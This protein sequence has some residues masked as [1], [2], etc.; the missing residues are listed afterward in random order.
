MLMKSEKRERKMKRIVIFFAIIG[1]SAGMALGQTDIAVAKTNLWIGG[2]NTYIAAYTNENDYSFDI[3]GRVTSPFLSK[4]G[5]TIIYI[6]DDT[7]GIRFRGTG[8]YFELETNNAVFKPGVEVT[9]WSGVIEQENG[10]RSVRSKIYDGD[11]LNEFN[12]IFISDT[13]PVPVVPQLITLEEYFADG[14][15]VEGA[16]IKIT[17]LTCGAVTWPYGENGTFTA[18]S[19]ASSITVYLDMDTEVPG[20]LPPTNAFDL[21]GIALQYDISAIPSNGYEIMPRYYSDF[22]QTVG[23]EPPEILVTP[24]SAT[25]KV[26][27]PITVDVI[28]Q[29]R[30]AADVLTIANPEAISGSSFVSTGARTKQLSWT[31]QLSDAGTIHTAVFTVADATVTVTGQTVITVADAYP[32]GYAWINEVHYNNVGDDVNEGVELA[33]SAGEDLG[34]YDVF[35]YRGAGTLVSSNACGGNIDDEGNGYGA[36]WFGYPKDA[37]PNTE[38]HGVALVHDVDGVMDFIS[39]GGSITATEGPASG[40]TSYDIGVVENP[41]PEL[42]YSLQLSGD[43]TNY[44]SF[45]WTGPVPASRGFLNFAQNVGGTADAAVIMFDLALLPAEPSTNAFDIVCSIFPNGSADSLSATAYYTLNGGT[46]NSVPMSLGEDY[47]YTTSSQIP[48]QPDGTVVSYWVGVTFG[49]PGTNSPSFTETNTYNI[50]ALAGYETFANFDPVN[51]GAYTDGDFLGQDGSTWTYTQCRGDMLITD[52]TPCLGNNRTPVAA[53]QSGTI[54]GGCGTLSFDLMKAFSADYNLEVYVNDNLVATLTGG[55]QSVVDSSGDIVVNAQ[56]DFVLKF[57]QA[58]SAAGQVSIDNITWTPPDQNAPS[59]AITNP[60]TSSVSVSNEVTSYMVEGSASTSVVGQISW[61]NALTGASGTTAAGTSWSQS[62]ALNV[63]VNVITF[64]GTNNVGASASDSVT[65]TRQSLPLGTVLMISQYYEGASNDKWIEL[66]NAGESTID[67]G[68]GGYRLGIWANAAREGWKTSV[69]P[70]ASIVLSNSIAAG[71]TYL[72]KHTDSANP[73]YAVGDIASGSLTPNG[74]DSVVLYTGETYDFANVV[75]AFGLTGSG[76]ADKSYVRANGLTSGV[77][78]DFAPGDWV[79]FSLAEVEAAGSLANEYLGYHSP[80]GGIDLSVTITNPATASLTVSNA[81]ITYA[82]QGTASSNVVGQL[83]WT[84]ALTGASG[85]I[86]AAAEWTISAVALN[87]GDNLITVSGTN[88]DAVVVS[89]SVTITRELAPP[90]IQAASA[91]ASTQFNAN[92]LASDGATGYRLDVATNESFSTGGVGGEALLDEDFS[93]LTDTAVPDGWST[94]GSSDLDYTGAGYYG[95]AP[96]AYK[97]KATGQW[98]E[99]P[100]FSAGATGLQFWALG[101][102]G[103]G[104][105]FTV[106]GLVNSA[107]T[108][109]DTVVI[110]S[111]GATYNVALDSQTTKFKISFTKVVNCG[112]DDVLVQGSAG[113]GESSFVPGY[114]NLDVGNVTTYAVTGLTEG[115]TYHYRVRAYNDT[116]TTIN[117]GVTNVTTGA[118]TTPE[119]TGFSVPAGA[120]ATVTLTTTINGETY[121]LEYTTDPTASP[122]VWTEADS[123]VGD[124]GELILTDASPSDVMR[125]Y[126]VVLQ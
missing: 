85:T 46:T 54:S 122:V 82:L 43:G 22:I 80:D 32:A 15:A 14:E 58:N 86:A 103:D 79:E 124:G 95:D 48:G 84:N 66:Y 117:S 73:T 111:G 18:T 36:I 118:S 33:G 112:L 1:M 116:V 91:V 13:N 102:S 99:S 35:V 51:V 31:P 67:L 57:I 114:Q 38:P 72:V 101:N 109:I 78:T 24:A 70:S 90:V 52:E 9:I 110:A 105:T 75:D 63:G 49:G 113:G 76:Y 65:I 83:S 108:L 42:D 81:V 26:G 30:N 5:D 87:V 25:A 125:I 93:T 77:N 4:S 120:T 19:G 94:S 59:L 44:E 71:D 27:R 8:T 45:V 17:N 98:L 47:S 55:T 121:A 107:W 92:W 115:V 12:D 34:V 106:S 40:M 39:W 3:K 62:V 53:V 7:A 20:Q 96:P 11:P 16:L 104:S 123:D 21:I 60:I 126:R 2:T 56:G 37:I 50:V 6:Q 88:A 29:D 100:S 89:D 10:M 28:G 69:A 68:A 64:S 61:T 23:A 74:D 97:F 119:I 41:P